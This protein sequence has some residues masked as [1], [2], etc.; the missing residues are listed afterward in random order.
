MGKVIHYHGWLPHLN[1]KRTFFDPIQGY[2]IIK[3]IFVF[4]F[5]LQKVL[6]ESVANCLV[7]KTTEAVADHVGIWDRPKRATGTNGAAGGAYLID[8][9]NHVV[10]AR[11]IKVKS[12]S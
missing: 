5:I 1:F 9:Q 4:W 3:L 2:H 8:P 12:I 10:L 7:D 6:N 11:N